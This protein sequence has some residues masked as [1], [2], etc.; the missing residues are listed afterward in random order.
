MHHMQHVARGVVRIRAETR[1]TCRT[2]KSSAA[3]NVRWRAKT[4]SPMNSAADAAFDHAAVDPVR[5]LER[6]RE[7]LDAGQR[8]E[9]VLDNRML[10]GDFVAA[11][12]P[13][14]TRNAFSD[15]HGQFDHDIKSRG[16]V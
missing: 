16:R 11:N 10:S 12:S 3:A 7:I 8:T 9:D 4:A 1:G 5:H 6:K 13:L 2:R 15:V 14:Q